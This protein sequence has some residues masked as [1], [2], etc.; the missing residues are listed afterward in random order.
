MPYTLQYFDEA[1]T[2]INEA[3]AWYKEQ[4][5]GLEIEFATAVEKAIERLLQTP[6]AYAVRYKTVRM[7]HPKKF[8]YNIHFYIDESNHTVVIT[9]IVHSKRHPKIA[10]K[11]I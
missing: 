6:R 11:R 8:P 2:D 10:R 4:Q 1:E 3:K 7:A 5:D 9:A